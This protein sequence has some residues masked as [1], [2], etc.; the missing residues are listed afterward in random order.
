ME[1]ILPNKNRCDRLAEG[2]DATQRL[3]RPAGGPV[4]RDLHERRQR[5]T[6]NR[7]CL[8]DSTASSAGKPTYDIQTK[9][10]QFPKCSVNVISGCHQDPSAEKRLSDQHGQAVMSAQV[11][12]SVETSSAQRRRRSVDHLDVDQSQHCSVRRAFGRPL[13]ACVGSCQR[14]S[15]GAGLPAD[16][17]KDLL[18][19]PLDRSDVQPLGPVAEE[20]EA[21][22][23][24]KKKKTWINA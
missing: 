15:S 16:P 19:E 24:A 14:S 10:P 11:H 17:G 23:S 13:R 7:S 21:G 20:Q 3:R 1:H 22:K 8:N 2:L 4:F 12:V 5:P 9:R 18:V 6:P